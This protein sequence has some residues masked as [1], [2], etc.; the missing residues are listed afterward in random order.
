MGFHTSIM[1]DIKWLADGH[2]SMDSWISR[3]AIR[4]P[5]IVA[6]QYSGHGGIGIKGH[7]YGMSGSIAHLR[8]LANAD[9]TLAWLTARTDQSFMRLHFP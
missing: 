7:G 2:I 1:K 9:P 8:P 5:D 6:I 3:K 4:L